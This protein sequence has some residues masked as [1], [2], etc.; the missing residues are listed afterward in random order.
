MSSYFGT[1]E[2]R[3][4][5]QWASELGQNCQGGGWGKKGRQTKPLAEGLTFWKETQRS[6]RERV[7]GQKKSH[8]ERKQP[9]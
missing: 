6:S 3:T 9:G 5:F 7:T 2:G 1:A 8:E 4:Q